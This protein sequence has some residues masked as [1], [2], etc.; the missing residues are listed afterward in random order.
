MTKGLMCVVLFATSAAAQLD[1]KT[2]KQNMVRDRGQ[3]NVARRSSETE[4]TGVLFDA[5]CRDRSGWNLATKPET[6]AGAL[7]VQP[8]GNTT[9]TG[10]GTAA[11]TRSQGSAQ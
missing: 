3:T 4:V 9:G 11:V 1:Q 6:L 5:A 7:P 2:D 10:A 8:A